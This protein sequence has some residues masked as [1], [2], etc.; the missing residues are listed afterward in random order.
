MINHLV[1]LI[2]KGRLGVSRDLLTIGP[3]QECVS[4]EMRS[5]KVEKS[6]TPAGQK[7]RWQGGGEGRC[8][9][10]YKGLR[11]AL[12]MRVTEWGSLSHWT[13]KLGGNFIFI[14]AL[15][16]HGALQGQHLLERT[17]PANSCFKNKP[18]AEKPNCLFSHPLPDKAIF[19]RATWLDAL[20]HTSPAQHQILTLPWTVKQALRLT[21]QWSLL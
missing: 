14:L 20:K 18:K 15:G 8:Q 19:L 1:L 3:S 4:L 10:K 5:L 12:G 21:F 9:D 6:V 7:S 2:C 13:Q 11:W 17:A 16:Q